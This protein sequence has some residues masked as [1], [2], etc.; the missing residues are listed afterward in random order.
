MEKC[1]SPA[2]SIAS[3]VAMHK[4]GNGIL[5]VTCKNIRHCREKKITLRGWNHTGRGQIDQEEDAVVIRAADF[6][7]ERK[8]S[9]K[10]IPFIVVCAP[11]PQ[12]ACFGLLSPREK[13]EVKVFA[14]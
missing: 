13:F 6:L 1:H 7:S 3:S 11:M 8:H 5:A 14:E 12:Q 9:G 4:N 10:N 2:R